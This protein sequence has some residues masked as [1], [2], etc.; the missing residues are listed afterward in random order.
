MIRLSLIILI[1]LATMPL[2]GQERAIKS[3]ETASKVLFGNMYTES[4]AFVSGVYN[5]TGG[6][7]DLDGVRKDIEAVSESLKDAGFK[8]ELHRN[9]TKQQFK[10]SLEKFLTRNQNNKRARLLV[11]FAGHG[12]T[13]K[14][15]GTDT[16]YV[17]MQDAALPS[18]DVSGFRNGSLPMSYFSAWGEQLRQKYVMFV[19]DSCFSGTVFYTTRSVPKLLEELL[20]KPVRQFISS[21]SADQ[22]VPDVSVFRRKF[23]T[24]I[25]GDADTDNNGVIT[26]SELGKYL[27]EAVS[28]YSAGTQTPMY[29]KLKGYEGEFVFLAEKSDQTAGSKDTVGNERLTEKEK[30][31]EKIKENPYSPDAEKYVARLREIDESLNTDPPVSAPERKNFTMTAKSTVIKKNPVNYYPFIVIAP[32]QVSS[33]NKVYKAAFRIKANNADSF[34]KLNERKYMLKSVMDRRLKES[35]LQTIVDSYEVRREIRATARNAVEWV[36]PNCSDEAPAIVGL[37]GL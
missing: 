19:F 30:L 7:S 29:G 18:E 14:E 27:K 31:I 9:Q 3:S 11:Y 25:E 28:S 34:K 37:A 36:C 22:L 12:H 17:V 4:Y 13:I 6:W 10:S 8:V 26:G 16:G 15:D 23:I 1:I 32:V 21:G 24:G 5:Y 20:E 33:K 2:Y 35:D